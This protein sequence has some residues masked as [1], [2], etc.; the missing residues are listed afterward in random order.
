MLTQEFINKIKYTRYS[1][2]DI[3]TDQLFIDRDDR[4]K[5]IKD[6]NKWSDSFGNIYHM[7]QN[8]R[9]HIKIRHIEQ[10]F[11]EI[12]NMIPTYLDVEFMLLSVENISELKEIKPNQKIFVDLKAMKINGE[13]LSPDDIYNQDLNFT[14]S[15]WNAAVSV[16]G[17]FP[18]E[19]WLLKLPF[20]EF[21][22]VVGRLDTV[23]QTR[24]LELDRIANYYYN[25]VNN[26]Y[27]NTTIEQKANIIYEDMSK[28]TKMDKRVN[29]MG[30]YTYI[31][32]YSGGDSIW[33]FK[34][35]TGICVGRNTLILIGLNNRYFNIKCFKV[36]GMAGTEKHGWVVLYDENNNKKYYDVNYNIKGRTTVPHVIDK[37]NNENTELNYENKGKKI[38][39]P[40]L[41][42]RR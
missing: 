2:N 9:L 20:E 21:V 26:T 19:E 3:L 22:P 28:N 4:P 38:T 39:P 35:N 36:G 32:K 14:F 41:P 40:P 27:P 30:Y 8:N 13:F 31:Q 33:T 24:A 15:S 10:D 12:L 16:D 11:S 17:I 7:Q 37:E 5:L 34:N 6:P 25:L 29:E 23:S 42:K 18:F 1:K